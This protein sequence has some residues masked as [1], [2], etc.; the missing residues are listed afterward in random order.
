MHGLLCTLPEGS[1]QIIDKVTSVPQAAIS[2]HDTEF[3]INEQTA[4]WA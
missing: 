4:H 1:W 3:C 2:G